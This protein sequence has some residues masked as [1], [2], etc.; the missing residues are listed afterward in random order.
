MTSERIGSREMPRSPS[1][2]ASAHGKNGYLWAAAV[3]AL[4]TAV[5]WPLHPFFDVANIV[6]LF[7]LA[8]AGVALR[9]GRGAAVLAAFLNVAAFDYFFVEPRLSFAVSD[10]QYLLTFAV[11]LV[12]GLVIGQLTA[13]LRLQARAAAQRE[14]RSHALY[15][16]ARDLSTALS[17]GQCVDI[18]ERAISREF[19]ATVRMLLLDGRDHLQAPPAAPAADIDLGTAQWALDHQEAAGLGTGT[20]PG[21]AWFYLPL[22][23]PTRTRGVLAFRPDDPGLLLVPEQ[24]RQLETFALLAAI[25][26]ERV[27]YVDAAQQA[28][29]QASSERL[30]NSLLSALSHDLRT[31]LASLYGLTDVLVDSM[32]P[33][34]ARETAQAISAEARRINA[35][36]NNLLDMARL[37]S[38]TVRLDRQWLPIEEVVGS[39]LRSLG[40]ALDGHAVRI[41]LAPGLPLVKLDAVLIERVL[42][43]LLENAAKYTPMN[44]TITLSARIAG[45]DLRVD[46]EDDGPGLPEGREEALFQK[47]TR[48]D[49]E[50]ARSGVGLGLA[51]CRAIVEAHGGRIW[52]EAASAREAHRG[53]RFSFALPLGEPPSMPLPEEDEATFPPS[54]P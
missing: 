41:E 4:T 54:T 24:R 21:S 29:V 13:G 50:S 14:A 39:A 49:P 2:D 30:R 36:V 32:P 35:M 47:F 46:V 17:A 43:N 6:M 34:P 25:A 31:P 40:A 45:A 51:I 15:E 8:V 33:I 5:A 23:A 28:T 20:L 19:G 27:H 18:A 16:A 12:V 11:M 3:C 26:L 10:A 52:A 53:A 44:S 42:A 1:R 22:R 37:Q 7:L 38:G 48:G 9:F